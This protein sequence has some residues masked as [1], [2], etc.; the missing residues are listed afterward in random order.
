M[1]VVQNSARGVNR[2]HGIR[3]VEKG[4]IR[5]SK[6]ALIANGIQGI[7]NDPHRFENLFRVDCVSS[8]ARELRVLF[9]ERLHEAG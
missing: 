8:W 4:W 5:M 3:L 2:E 6:T 1:N 9:A 7:A